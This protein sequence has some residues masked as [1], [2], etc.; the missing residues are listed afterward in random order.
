[1]IGEMRPVANLL[2]TGPGGSAR[3]DNVVGTA[4]YGQRSPWQGGNFTA[5]FDNNRSTSNNSFNVLNPQYSTSLT[6][7]YTQPLWRNRTMDQPRRQIRIAKKRLDLSDNQ[8]RQ[9]AVEIIAQVQRAYWDLVFARRD[10]DIKRESVD[11]AQTQLEHNRRLVEA[12]ALA[13]ADVTSGTGSRSSVART[14]PE[15]AV[16]AIQRAENALKSL[17]LQPSNTEQWRASFEPIEIP[18]VDRAAEIPL[19]DAS[20]SRSPIARRRNSIG[21]EVI[22]IRSTQNSIG[23]R[24]SHRS[25]SFRPTGRSVSRALPGTKSIRSRRVT[26]R[27]SLDSMSFRLFT[28]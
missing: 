17:V 16:D 3:T 9:R 12:G 14:K 24:Q 15:A 7:T 19:G 21:C 28:A 23:T 10:R 25:T 11:L 2:V 4:N 22:S 1:M 26:R 27:P 18:Q 20:S 5:V 13:P 6:F 8:F